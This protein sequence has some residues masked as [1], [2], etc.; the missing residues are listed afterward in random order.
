MKKQDPSQRS[1]ML[2]VAKVS[3]PTTFTQ[4]T[5]IQSPVTIKSPRIS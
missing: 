3:N 4:K 2:Q 5:D 1:K